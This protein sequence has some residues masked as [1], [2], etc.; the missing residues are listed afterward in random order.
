MAH[1][2]WWKRKLTRFILYALRNDLCTGFILFAVGFLFL[3]FRR[4]WLIYKSKAAVSIVAP[5]VTSIRASCIAKFVV[6]S[7]VTNELVDPPS[8]YFLDIFGLLCRLNYV[9]SESY[10]FSS[11]TP[12]SHLRSLSNCMNDFFQVVFFIKLMRTLQK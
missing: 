3:F 11:F 7:V 6:L 10:H 2:R 4:L 9:H 1:C 8:L 5:A 12:F